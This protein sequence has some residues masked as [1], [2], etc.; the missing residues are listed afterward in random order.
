[1]VLFNIVAKIL[2][3]ALSFDPSLC[4]NNYMDDDDDGGGGGDGGGGDDDDDD[5]DDNNNNNNNNVCIMITSHLKAR[6]YQI[7]C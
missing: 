1:V 2:K 7:Y 3:K 4:Q 6:I 5:D